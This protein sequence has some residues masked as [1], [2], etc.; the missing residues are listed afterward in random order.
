M[1]SNPL[2]YKNRI[3]PIKKTMAAPQ[4]PFIRPASPTK[5]TP[6]MTI[7]ASPLMELKLNG[8]PKLE[9]SEPLTK[10]AYSNPASL[11]YP[12]MQ[13]VQIFSG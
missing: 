8:E 11:L 6:G 12:G 4:I 3:I 13:G 2:R 10:T 9:T 1:G 7:K 5:A